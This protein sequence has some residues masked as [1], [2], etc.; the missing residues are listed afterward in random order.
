MTW[1]NTRR[2][3]EEEEEE[4]EEVYVPPEQ[5]EESLPVLPDKVEAQIYQP[6]CGLDYDTGWLQCLRYGR[7]GRRA[8]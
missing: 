4:E 6:H 3:R 5:E 1:Q 2:D 8:C 7:P